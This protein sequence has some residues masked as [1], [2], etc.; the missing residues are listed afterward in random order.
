MAQKQKHYRVT[1]Y[2]MN[3]GLGKNG[4]PT[5]TEEV[6]VC[7]RNQAEA[8]RL[9]VT[10]GTVC[11]EDGWG[12]WDSVEVDGKGRKVTPKKAKTATKTATK[13][14]TGKAREEKSVELFMNILEYNLLGF[15][16]GDGLYNMFNTLVTS[17]SKKKMEVLPDYH[18]DIA[19]GN[20]RAMFK[21]RIKSATGTYTVYASA[22]RED[23]GNSRLVLVGAG[24]T[25]FPF[26]EKGVREI[27]KTI[28]V[29]K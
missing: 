27:V 25:Q 13:K 19:Q 5:E 12:A 26:S 28:R 18:Y 16:I 15:R 24:K 29:A 2:N 23:H 6:T 1:I 3:C 10:G 20:H 17:I 11:R 7:A 8:E 21:F 4:K 9:A 22:D 14:L